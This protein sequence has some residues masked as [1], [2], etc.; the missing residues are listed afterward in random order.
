M[1]R[2]LCS[3]RPFGTSIA[4][5]ESWIAGY[6]REIGTTPLL[7][8]HE[9][10]E[11]AQRVQ[12]GDYAARDHLVRANLRLVVHLARPYMAPGL[13]FQ[14][15]VAEGNL[16]LLRAVERFDPTMGTR[17][18]TYASY[19][20]KQSI[21][22]SIYNWGRPIRLPS[23]LHELMIK[24]HRATVELQERIGRVPIEDEVAHLLKLSKEK[25]LL[26]RK[27]LRVQH[28]TSGLQRDEDQ[29]S[30][31]EQLPDHRTRSPERDLDEAEQLQLALAYLHQLD[32]RESAVLRMRFGLEGNEPMT[33]IDIGIHM[34]VTRERVR[35]IEQR[36][37]RKLREIMQAN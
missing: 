26:I 10:R 12:E 35:Q 23:Y 27:A 19:W 21:R 22:R 14:D 30:L 16:G 2:T 9:E 24:W 7:S 5:T 32:S 31:Q 18:S 37:L 3:T 8:A 20:I 1:A 36:A 28:V 11:L 34:G 13:S 6:L 29:D 25:F 15:L 17:F 4:W 33:L